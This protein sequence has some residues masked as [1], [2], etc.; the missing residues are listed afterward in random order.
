MYLDHSLNIDGKKIVKFFFQTLTN[1][2]P[3]SYDQKHN[4]HMTQNFMLSLLLHGRL[5]LGP[6]STHIYTH[7]HLV[8]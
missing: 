6:K 1:K 8:L 7:S 3:N 2:Q 5:L 4:F